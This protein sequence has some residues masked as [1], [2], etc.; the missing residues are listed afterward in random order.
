MYLTFQREA[1]SAGE[2]FVP[3]EPVPEEAGSLNFED[4]ALKASFAQQKAQMEL[5]AWGQ[6]SKTIPC[7]LFFSL[8]RQIQWLIYPF[9]FSLSQCV[10][11][12]PINLIHKISDPYLLVFH[13]I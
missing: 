5:T 4:Y 7:P 9:I 10:F 1:A 8:C 11:H 13:K 3:V 6:S 12:I 2:G